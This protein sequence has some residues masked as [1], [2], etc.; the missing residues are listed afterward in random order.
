MNQIQGSRSTIETNYMI[1]EISMVKKITRKLQQFFLSKSYTIQELIQIHGGKIGKGVFIG[2][3]VMIDYDYAFLLEI[4]DGAVISART[5]LEFHDSCLPNVLGR[6]KTKI[7]KIKIGNRAY[8]GVNSVLLAGVQIGDGAIVGACSLV[9]R[10]IPGGE[11]WG[12]IPAGFIC[13]IDDLV[14]KSNSS[15][16]LRV[17]YF[18]WI[19]ELEKGEIN[20]QKYKA[21]FIHKVRRFFQGV[22]KKN[23]G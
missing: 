17:A 4:G 6:A 5:I 9:N 18:D 22:E 20:Y 13:S 1:K 23:S 15:S 11:V 3:D 2:S 21:N 7:G 8:I 16:D 14:K 10:N 12:G 19:G